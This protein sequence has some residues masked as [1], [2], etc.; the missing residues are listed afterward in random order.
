VGES[1]SSSLA[2]SSKIEKHSV[3]AEPAEGHSSSNFYFGSSKEASSMLHALPHL[4]PAPFSTTH[5][6][7]HS[8]QHYY[9]AL[10][11][12]KYH[13]L[14]PHGYSHPHSHHPHHGYSS[15]H[16]STNSTGGMFYSGL[17]EYSSRSNLQPS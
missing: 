10:D 9:Q 11:D 2:L 7:P 3:K 12:M 13:S 17:P 16:C 1:Q 8:K 6:Y 14:H 15:L 4:T 5:P